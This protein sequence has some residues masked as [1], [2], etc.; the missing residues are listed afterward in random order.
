VI[1]AALA[2]A[3]AAAAEPRFVLTGKGWGHGI[4]LSQYGAYGYAQQGWQDDAI[5]TH[6]Y[7]GAAVTLWVGW[8]VLVTVGTFVGP[9]VATLPVATLLP[10]LEREIEAIDA[11]V[12]PIA[13]SPSERG[14]AKTQRP[15]SPTDCATTSTKAATSWSVT[16]SRSATASTVKEALDRAASAAA[17]GTTPSSAQASVAANGTVSPIASRG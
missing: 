13:T 12:M 11:R 17:A 8:P 4:G 5:L 1:L 2:V 6:Y 14:S 15:C 9:V 16:F 3:P 7:T 10:T